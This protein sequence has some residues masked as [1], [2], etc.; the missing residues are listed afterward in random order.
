MTI[1]KQNN[2]KDENKKRNLIL[3]AYNTYKYRDYNN[4]KSWLNILIVNRI[5]FIKIYNKFYSTNKSTL[6]MSLRDLVDFKNRITD[7]KPYQ[8]LLKDKDNSEFKFGNGKLYPAYS[9]YDKFED[10]CD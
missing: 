5:Y 4:L 6:I 9:E 8:G 7:I 3:F 2:T 1:Q 10:I